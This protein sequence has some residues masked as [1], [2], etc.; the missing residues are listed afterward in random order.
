MTA[1]DKA[2]GFTSTTSVEPSRPG[3]ENEVKQFTTSVSMGISSLKSPLPPAEIEDEE[4]AIISTP[5][6]KKA[7]SAALN[8]AQMKRL[9]DTISELMPKGFE[10]DTEVLLLEIA[11]ELEKT[12]G[13]LQKIGIEAEVSRRKA[14]IGELDKKQKEV[15]ASRQKAQKKSGIAKFFSKI[16]SF[17]GAIA[18][19]IGGAILAL[20]CPPAGAFVFAIGALM[21]VNEFSN[22]VSGKTLFAHMGLS[23]KAQMYLTMGLTIAAAVV[24]I[25]AA[26]KA[27][28]GTAVTQAAKA[29]AT[30][31]AKSAATAASK[32][33]VSQG[34]KAA[35]TKTAGIMGLAEAAMGAANAGVQFS[36]S[37][38][39]VDAKRKMAEYKDMEALIEAMKDFLERGIKQY[40]DI[41]QAV[42]ELM[43]KAYE[44]AKNKQSLVMSVKLKA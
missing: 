26:I 11:K 35:M 36:A 23:E 7:E 29:A 38:S 41:E 39:N 1:L 21:A 27:T 37:S 15:E 19:M 22:L 30:E 4:T 34:T 13:D 31:G 33:L 16:F 40:S 44:S 32:E 8:M 18:T 2:S 20:T 12:Q 24:S 6:D 14:D 25:G 5:G 10:S 28:V 9:L 17:I 43:E 42:Q 3:S